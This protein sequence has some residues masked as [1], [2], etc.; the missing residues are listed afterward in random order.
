MDIVTSFLEYLNTALSFEPA[1]T[2]SIIMRTLIVSGIILFVI[3]WI[4][5]KGVNQLTAYQLIIILSLGNIVAEPMLNNDAPILSMVTVVVIIIVL[6]KLL[7]YVSAKNKRM[8]KIINPDVIEL[9][10]DGQMD[11]EGMIKARIGMKEYQS[12]MRLAGIRD[13]QEIDISNLEINGQISFIKKER[14]G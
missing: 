4:G 12:F 7:D 6:F 3:K 5:S 8:E 13:I 2:L 10:K 9:V 14:H 1:L 11:E